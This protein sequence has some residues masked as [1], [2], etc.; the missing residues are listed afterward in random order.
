MSRAD[1]W[2]SVAEKAARAAG[3]HALRNHERRGEAVSRSAHDVKLRLDIE[4]QEVAEAVIRDAFPEHAITGEEN[5]RVR[6]GADVE[7]VIDPIDG[8][9]NFSHGLPLWCCSVAATRAGRPLAG[10]VY[11]PSSDECFT[12][13]EN[14]PALCNGD[15][16]S[17]S[18]VCEFSRCMVATGT[19]NGVD[20]SARIV[21]V[22]NDLLPRVQKIRIL[23]AAAV[24]LCY[25]ACGR[26]EGYV[27]ASIYPWDIRA[28]QLLVE[29]AG[30]RFEVLREWG[31]SRM[32][33]LASNGL[34]HDDLR[35]ASL[36]YFEGG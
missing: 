18:P 30:G 4:C 20:D 25:V 11:I 8:T 2:V 22:M 35:S 9:V 12:A 21:R 19:L 34:V 31:D 27:E 10:A 17:V 1:E 36:P 23:G 24:D 15:I 7:W 32:A 3:N 28:G 13:T 33:V 29:R 26:L 5:S 6:D 14:G 16:I